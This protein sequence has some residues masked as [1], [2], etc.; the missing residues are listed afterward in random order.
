MDKTLYVLTGPTAVGKTALAMDWAEKNDAEILSGDSLLFY[1]GMDIGT[2]KP[3]LE[4][5][6]RVNHFGIDLIDV[7]E[8]FNVKKYITIAQDAVESIW[9]RGKKVLITGGSGFY[10]KCFYEPV[11]DDWPENEAVRLQIEDTY[12]KQGLDPLLTSLKSINCGKIDGLDI[13]NPRRV[14]RALERCLISKKSLEELRNDFK[15]QVG[16][17]DLYAKKTCLLTRAQETLKKRIELRVIKMLETGLIE[18]VEHLVEL[19]IEN[20]RSARTAIGYR[21]VLDYL[22]G[23][24]KKTDLSDL[25]I[26]NTIK[27]ASKQ[28]KWFRYQLKHKTIVD[29]DQNNISI[30]DLF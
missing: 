28:R 24:V 7:T 14:M 6:R 10:L 16:P 3:T 29:L 27:L 8:S 11:I 1:K 17:F 30:Q 13:E 15:K 2:A 25:I 12:L 26:Q 18:E 9:N 22:A 4:E 5:R 20:N 21:E 19:G 23:K